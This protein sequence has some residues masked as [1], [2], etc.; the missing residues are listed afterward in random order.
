[1]F[2]LSEALSSQ[3]AILNCDSFIMRSL[4]NSS[5]PFTRSTKN[6]KVFLKG[7]LINKKKNVKQKSRKVKIIIFKQKNWPLNKF[8]LFVSGIQCNL[9][10][11]EIFRKGGQRPCSYCILIG[12]GY[13]TGCGGNHKATVNFLKK[14]IHRFSCLRD[15]RMIS[16]ERRSLAYGWLSER[17]SSGLVREMPIEKGKLRFRVKKGIIKWIWV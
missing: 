4:P 3:M 7:I 1:M 6:P 5:F 10:I 15:K 14:E 13:G 8:L 2:F 11:E 16:K 12:A 17:S 9:Y